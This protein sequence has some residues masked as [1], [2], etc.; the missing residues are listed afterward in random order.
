MLGLSAA[1]MHTL[2]TPLVSY[3]PPK[4]ENVKGEMNADA[5][6]HIVTNLNAVA[7]FDSDHCLRGVG[8]ASTRQSSRWAVVCTELLSVRPFIS[9]LTQHEMASIGVAFWG[10]SLATSCP[11]NV[12][13]EGQQGWVLN[14]QFD[15]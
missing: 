8:P 13:Q 9:A 3:T 2:G 5:S 4:H 6:Y 10:A 7:T 12:S 14:C 15:C 11:Y 1:C